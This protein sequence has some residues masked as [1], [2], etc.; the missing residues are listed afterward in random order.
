M[1]YAFPRDRLQPT[2]LID[3]I[4]QGARS[5]LL[6]ALAGSV[7][8][9]ASSSSKPAELQ[10]TF[11]GDV[12]QPALSP[13]G[14]QVAY[15]TY[16]DDGQT[17]I[18][19]QDITDRS[20][21]RELARFGGYFDRTLRW[22]PSGTE[23]YAFGRL[24]EG[25]YGGA[26][27]SAR[28]GALRHV[29]S[30]SMLA[31]FSPD[32]RSLIT[33]SPFEP[34]RV[35]VVDL[36]TD[37]TRPIPL[38]DSFDFIESLDVSPDGKWIALQAFPAPKRREIWTVQVSGPRFNRVLEG[39]AW[40]SMLGPRWDPTGSGIYYTHD[41]T[42][43]RIEISSETGAPTSSPRAVL[44]KK[45]IAG[46]DLSR[47]GRRI[48]LAVVGQYWSELSLHAAPGSGGPAVRQIPSRGILTGD[49][50]ISPDGRE[51]AFVGGETSLANLYRMPLDGGSMMQLTSFS[52]AALMS[53][54]WSP[55]G[56]E[57]AFVVH[58]GQTSRI[59]RI[60]A[61]GGTP[62][63][64]EGTEGTIQIR[65]APGR[66]ILFL[67]DPTRAFRVIDPST[68]VER[69]LVAEE[70]GEMAH[71]RYSPDGSRVAVHR[72]KDGPGL[73]VIEIA[74]GRTVQLTDGIELPVGWSPEGDAV[75]A[76][77]LDPGTI[78]R[79]PLDG[80]PAETV[81]TVLCGD[82][83]PWGVEL[84]PDG[85]T[86]LCWGLRSRSDLWILDLPGRA[87]SAER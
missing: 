46:L 1:A 10:L 64:M 54:V 81:F 83:H 23:L 76:R 52:D 49:P 20:E 70:T 7:P 15:M 57:I 45:G 14:T 9:C 17:V 13:D 50:S 75:Y 27:V 38:P 48:A 78:V 2:Q 43:F 69:A 47:D 58:E 21:P 39:D 59:W 4:K 87:D 5:L 82:P 18:V 84:T 44:T 35:E 74:D 77:H 80:G 41:E 79:V 29:R 65:W 11:T 6:L 26:L 72:V 73:H 40:G 62:L 61:T 16:T 37:N 66:E 36:A 68:G 12:R 33:A 8:Q 56:R 85:R 86:F 24:P 25:Y 30:G 34:P 60:A 19:V 28:D 71:P 67:R 31:G 53:P 42:L 63:P 22:S 3:Q 32:G 55:D 51:I